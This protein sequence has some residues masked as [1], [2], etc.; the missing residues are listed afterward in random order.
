MA[1]EYTVSPGLT[2]YTTPVTGGIET[3][4]PSLTFFQSILGLAHLT[5][6]IETPNFSAIIERLS[7]SLTVYSET[8]FHGFSDSSVT[9]P[10]ESSVTPR[11]DTEGT[12]SSRTASPARLDCTNLGPRIIPKKMIAIMAECKNGRAYLPRLW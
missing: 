9:T 12:A 4:T 7:P 2:L 11:D 10:V 1:I 5:D 3:T 8:W 6:S